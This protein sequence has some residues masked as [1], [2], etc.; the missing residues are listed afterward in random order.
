MAFALMQGKQFK[1][2]VKFKP[3]CVSKK[4]KYKA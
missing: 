4:P 2:T 1:L 3:H